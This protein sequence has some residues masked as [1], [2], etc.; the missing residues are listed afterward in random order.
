MLALPLQDTV[1]LVKQAT[2][3][4]TFAEM[5]GVLK[6]FISFMNI[7]VSAWVWLVNSMADNE[8]H[9]AIYLIL[10]WTLARVSGETDGLITVACR[11]SEFTATWQN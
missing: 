1:D 9:V 10:L 11:V 7:T 5:I 4:K 6:K 3:S 2:P 8:I